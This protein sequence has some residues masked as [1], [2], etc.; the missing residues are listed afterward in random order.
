MINTTEENHDKLYVLLKAL[1]G[2]NL[3]ADVAARDVGAFS[4]AVPDGSAFA[5]RIC[6]ALAA[7]DI[8]LLRLDF[9]NLSLEEVFMEVIK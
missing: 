2:E 1:S 6:H 3:V 9:D 7:A 5:G 8:P 4:A